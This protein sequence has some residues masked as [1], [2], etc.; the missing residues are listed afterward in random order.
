MTVSGAV[1][2]ICPPLVPE[3]TVLRPDDSNCTIF[4]KYDNLGPV[5]FVCLKNL[6]FN[7]VLETCEYP[8]NV[9]CY[10]KTAELF[11]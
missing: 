1:V 3:N 8:E 7:P 10:N 9:E 4:Y 11:P 2:G 6:F 5:L